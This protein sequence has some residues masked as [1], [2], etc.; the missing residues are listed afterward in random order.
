MV[1]QG[2]NLFPVL[3]CLFLNDLEDFLDTNNCFGIDLEIKHDNNTTFLKVMILLYADD[4]VIFAM[5]PA[6]FQRNLNVFIDYTRL[7]K[8]SVN[9]SKTKIMIFGYCNMNNFRFQMDRNILE[10]TDSFK[11]LGVFVSKT[12][13][14][15]KA[16]KH[17]Y[18]Q[19]RK[20]MHL[21]LG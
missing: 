21:L 8:L 20:A 10:I 9:Y 13:T 19:A 2:K 1:R 15:Y 17:S 18:D 4:T 16:R 5:D 3:F 7:W 12:Q 6:S 14:F 11:Y